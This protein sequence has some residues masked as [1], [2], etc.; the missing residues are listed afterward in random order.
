MN[1]LDRLLAKAEASDKE[2]VEKSR[3]VL[4]VVFETTG[5]LGFI[6]LGVAFW[7]LGYSRIAVVYWIF[8]GLLSLNVFIGLV[9]GR[10]DI[11]RFNA[12][13]LT[14]VMPFVLMFFFG[15]FTTLGV[16]VVGG[17]LLSPI[18]AMMLVKRER[19]IPLIAGLIL[20]LVLMLPLQPY[21]SRM[22]P[23]IPANTAAVFAVIQLAMFFLAVSGL[24][25]IV[26]GR[27]EEANRRADAL[28]LNVLPGPIAKR[29]KEG[30]DRVADSHGQVTVLFA[31]IVDFTPM[32]AGMSAE[33]VVGLLN[34]VFSAFDGI[35]TSMELEKI[36]TVGDEYMVASGL[37]V[38]R[39][40]HAT[41]M[42]DFALAIRDTLSSQEFGGHKI[43]MRIGINSGP[44]VAGIIGTQ[45][46]AYDL[47]GDVVNTASRMESEGLA[48][49]IQ[50]ST[51]TYELVKGKFIC[52]PRGE[53]MIKGK[54]TMPTYLLDSRRA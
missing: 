51:T 20:L 3:V 39:E 37:P 38:P 33:E 46:F 45:K 48:D 47:W 22:D 5:L 14:L 50:I 7:L 18:S 23:H 29:L 31:D 27:L 1:A 41:A 2:R 30:T 52:E 9:L 10:I 24:S 19:A 42:A 34:E 28:L 36:K 35:V 8:G 25:F 12:L 44:V 13:T 49:A 6:G 11:A 54:G 16:A 40:D 43:R 53:V 15:G 4:A 26:N 17:S 32:S 21:A